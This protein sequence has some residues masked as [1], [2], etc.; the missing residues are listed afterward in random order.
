MTKQFGFSPEEA[1]AITDVLR[2][3]GFVP[4]SALEKMDYAGRQGTDEQL[5]RTE[6][7]ARVRAVVRQN[8]IGLKVIDYSAGSLQTLNHDR[9]IA[10]ARNSDWGSGPRAPRFGAGELGRSPA[11]WSA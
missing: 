2:E 8:F 6:M 7:A 11:A 5:A 9:D 4:K 1:S 3:E 10:M